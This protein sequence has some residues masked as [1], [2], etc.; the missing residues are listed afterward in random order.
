MTAPH[1]SRV[2]AV[3]PAPGCG[4]YLVEGRCRRCETLGAPIAPDAT[5]TTQG[6]SSSGAAPSAP[7]TDPPEPDER[8][9]PS[10][11]PISEHKTAAEASLLPRRPGYY[12]GWLRTGN[13]GNRGGGRYPPG[14]RAGMRELV[15]IHGLPFLERI[16]RRAE[17][18]YK[19]TKGGEIVGIPISCATVLRAVIAAMRGGEADVAV[20]PAEKQKPR[21]M[22]V[23]IVS[24]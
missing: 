19:L 14:T 23:R 16:M 1:H 13:P 9:T 4:W 15:R 2:L 18:D 3:C 6:P 11:T 10:Q 21:C 17:L 20:E 24:E 7:P 22:I 5:A 12:G 8:E